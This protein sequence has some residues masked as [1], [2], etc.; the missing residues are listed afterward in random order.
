MK[1]PA[2]PVGR[3]VTRRA[4]RGALFSA[5]ALMLSTTLCYAGLVPHPLRSAI[6]VKSIAYERGFAERSGNAVIAVV[7]GKSGAS[8]EDGRSMASVLG[9]VLAEMRVAGRKATVVQVVHESNTETVEALARHRAEVVY[10]AS[11]LESVTPAIPPRHD[12]IRRI[13]VCADGTTVNGGCT[14]GVELEREKPRLV[15]NVRQANAAG[16][17]FDPGLLKLARTVR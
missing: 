14:L 5:F 2:V 13:V 6:V 4:A 16:L 7:V 15:L 8:A 3:T 9:K 11:G 17:R 1:R 10:V 12:Q